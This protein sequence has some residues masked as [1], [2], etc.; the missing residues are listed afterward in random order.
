MD[1]KM[2]NLPSPLQL[3]S[4]GIF[5][6]NEVFIKREDLI[7][8][9]ISGNK[10][11]KLKYNLM[12]CTNFA[13][14]PVISFGGA[15]SNHLA[16]L[17]FAC[18]QLKINSIGIIRGEMD[19]ENPSIRNLINWNMHLE[20]VSRAEFKAE[21]RSNLT[22]KYRDRFPKACIIPEGG[23]NALAIQ[24]I[25]EMMEE[26][27]N[28]LSSPPDIIA[29]SL[30]SGGTS[31]GI[32]RNAHPDTEIMI[33][34]SFKGSGQFEQYIQKLEDLNIDLHPGLNYLDGYHFGGFARFNNELIEFIL[35]WES[36]TGIPL[37]PVYTAKLFYAVSDQIR[38]RELKN[39]KIVIIH[40]GGLQ[41]RQGFEYLN[42]PLPNFKL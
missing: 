1:G 6:N 15:F 20:F 22:A 8:P 3:I 40:T 39:K 19:H 27:T 41:G 24:G 38:N 5:G 12:H 30:G 17:A 16:A 7:H 31:A 23:T 28:Q 34:S 35:N 18:F 14:S 37:D 21:N 10:Y 9:V 42:G 29:V 33:S 13:L 36:E 32:V 11:R 2:F 25:G 26:L 4:S